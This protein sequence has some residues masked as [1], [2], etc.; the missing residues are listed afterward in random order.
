MVLSPEVEGE[1]KYP[2]NP[3]HF[4]VQAGEH[5]LFTKSEDSQES[6]SV[7]FTGKRIAGKEIW[8]LLL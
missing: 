3:Q 7:I 4:Q 5:C 2:E 6:P 8:E 1:Q